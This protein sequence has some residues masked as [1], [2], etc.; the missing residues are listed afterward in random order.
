MPE[1][2][3]ESPQLRRERIAGVVAAALVCL[4]LP[5]AVLVATDSPVPSARREAVAWFVGSFAFGVLLPLLFWAP[6]RA[7]GFAAPGA[8]AWLLAVVGCVAF[9]DGHWPCWIHALPLG[10]VIGAVVRGRRGPQPGEETTAVFGAALLGSAFAWLFLSRGEPFDYAGYFLLLVALTLVW[11]TWTRLFRPC[12]ELTLELPVWF[13]YKIR[14]CGPGLANFPR[15]GP[16]IVLA[17]HACWF[18]PLFLAKVLPRPITPMMTARF[19]DLP[20]LR[21]LMLCFGTIRVPEKAMKRDT[22]ELQDAIAA[23]DRG[24]CVVIFPEG[25]LRRT[26]EQPLRR[27]GQGIWQILKARPRT[28]VFA[29]WIEGGWGSYASYF[30]GKPTKNKRPDVRRTIAIGVADAVTVPEEV[31]QEHLRT[32]IHLMNLSSA[33]R[34]F[35]GLAKLPPF[36]V[37]T[38]HEEAADETEAVS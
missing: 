2:E 19:Y 21:W 17:N 35:L 9:V 27:F 22:A 29:C 38:K 4:A 30:N 18:D 6:F 37:P 33:A 36:E 23:L 1:P 15:T 14:G 25:Y 16:C 28:P 7:L 20:G 10:V 5:S 11:W 12:V 3:A 32:R 8:L 31:L 26:E 24:E 13:A 34:E